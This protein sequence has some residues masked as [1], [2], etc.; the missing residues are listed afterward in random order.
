MSDATELLLM[1]T[2]LVGWTPLHYAALCAPP[3]LI[4]YLIRNGASP[5]A[6]TKKSLT[7]LDLIASYDPIPERQDAA[8]ILR[9]AMRERG[10][11]GGP[12]DL[13]RQ[14]REN[15]RKTRQDK[16]KKRF[17]EWNRIGHLLG[18][19]KH[20]WNVRS[21]RNL[22]LAE[23]YDYMSASDDEDDHGDEVTPDEELVSFPRLHTA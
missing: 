10:W 22:D 1:R 6:E 18:I 13:R 3:T 17:G 9:E 8:L 12:I 20:W 2:L 21:T 5:L 11:V 7:P 23:D 4:L 16:L 19:N 15:Q 14:K